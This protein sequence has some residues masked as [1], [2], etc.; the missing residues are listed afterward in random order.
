MASGDW[1]LAFGDWL[2]ASGKWRLA[3]GGY[4][5]IIVFLPRPK[6]CSWFL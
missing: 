5:V 6:I 4:S 3:F 2:L 1:L